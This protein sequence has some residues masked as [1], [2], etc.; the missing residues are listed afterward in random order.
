MDEWRKRRRGD[1]IN[2][3]SPINWQRGSTS[4]PISLLSLICVDEEGIIMALFEQCERAE[5]RVRADGCGLGAWSWA[6]AV[7]TRSEGNQSP[8]RAEGGPKQC[9]VPMSPPLYAVPDLDLLYL[10]LALLLTDLPGPCALV[11]CCVFSWSFWRET[12]QLRIPHILGTVS[13]GSSVAGF[14]PGRQ[15]A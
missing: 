6:E 3:C 14:L 8:R 10:A 4:A 15:G 2:G 9:V 13:P 12:A 1:Q 7:P 5:E 11:G